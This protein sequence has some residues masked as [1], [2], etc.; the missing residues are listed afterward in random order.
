MYKWFLAWRYLHTR[1]IA[2]FGVAAVTLCVAMVLVVLS[3]MGGFLDTIRARSRGLHSEIVLEGG[4]LQGFPY[5][6]EFAA[7]VQG[8][9]PDVVR[10]TTPVVY[11]YGIF[12]VPATTYT[13]PCRVLGVRLDD[14][15]QVNDF[16][17]GL[18]YNKYYPD[19]THLGPQAMPV[20]GFTPDGVL[21][22][23]PDL[24]AANLKWRESEVDP[25]ELA[26]FDAEPFQIAH[27]P[28]VT[29]AKDGVRVYSADF[30]GPAYV[31]LAHDGVIVGY[32]LLFQRPKEG[33]F[34]RYLARGTDVALTLMPLSPMGNPTGEPPVRLP[35]RYVDDSRTGIFEIDEFCVY[36][37][38]DM[39]QHKLAMDPQPMAD[40]ALTKARANQLLIG[41]HE[42]VELNAARDRIAELWT[43]FLGIREAE[44]SEADRHALALAE[45]LTWEDL[46][47]A[48]IAAVEKEKV[49]VTILFSLISLVA[50]V[51]VGCIF[52]MIVEKKTRDIGI[53]KALGASSSG[54]GSMFIAYAGAVGVTG[55]IF[56]IAVGCLFVWNVNDIQDWLA[57]LN[58]QLRV[59]SPDV[60]SFDR[61]PEVVKQADAIWVAGIAIISSMVGSLIPAFLA[62]RVWPVEVLRYE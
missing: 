28:Y 15:V 33:G 30:G 51:L 25:E 1:L 46:Q 29:P 40:G 16:A 48:F 43:T 13:K 62:G 9:L 8:R 27:Y 53:L 19:T 14:Y 31:G 44:L 59:W 56:G 24:E 21:K 47:R 32:D 35:L 37:D 22:L 34:P 10:L 4:T 38:F 55:S 12:R 50:I 54:V 20:A 3:V 17:K 5:Y 11:T 58:P 39:V 2:F 7:Y 18:H 49:L 26:E 57:S 60:Y 61:I 45:V 41:L 42:G 36:V 23:P 52:Y 6:A